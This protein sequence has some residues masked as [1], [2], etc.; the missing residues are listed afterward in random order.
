MVKTTDE[1][2]AFIMSEGGGDVSA[3][4]DILRDHVEEQLV[5]FEAKVAEAFSHLSTDSDAAADAAYQAEELFKKLELYRQASETGAKLYANAVTSKLD[6][7]G[8]ARVAGAA[9]RGMVSVEAHERARAAL[10]NLGHIDRTGTTPYEA[11]I[12]AAGW[13]RDI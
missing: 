7:P 11:S 9:Y 6:V 13:S 12:S 2:G 5:L 10:V 8:Q 4:A 3:F 1:I